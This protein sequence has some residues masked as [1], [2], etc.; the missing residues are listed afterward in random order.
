MQNKIIGSNHLLLRAAQEY[1]IDQGYQVKILSDRFTGDTKELARFHASLIQS[2]GH[3]RSSLKSPIILLSGGETTVS[4]KGQGKGGRNQEF[5][6]WLLYFLGAESIW[7]LT[8][9]SD[10]IDGNS[11]AAGAFLSPDSFQRAK[12]KGL[13]IEKYLS[14]NDS[15]SFFKA[16]GDT[17]ETGPTQHNLNDFRAILIS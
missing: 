11:S 6:L 5:A 12:N 16:L 7:S 15:N 4:V 8:C 13:D 3:K 9:G 10:G 1:L 14:D 17:L 2:I